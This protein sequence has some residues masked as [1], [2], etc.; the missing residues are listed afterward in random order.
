MSSGTSTKSASFNIYGLGV[1]LQSTSTTA[2]DGL[3]SDF[4][5]FRVVAEP[6]N[7]R[8]VELVQTFPPYDSVPSATATV[9]TPRNVSFRCGDHTYIDYS[10]RGLAIFDQMKGNVRI[11]STDSELL[12]E[13]AYLFLLSQVSEFLDARRMHRV[14]ALAVSLDGRAVLVLLPMGGGKST[15]GAELLKYPEMKFLS[16][17]SPFVDRRGRIHCFPLR[18]G[19]LPDDQSMV[20][21]DQI[22]RINRMEFGPKLLVNYAHFAERICPSSEPGVVFLGRR[23]MARKC[24][25]LPASWTDAVRAMVAN[26]VVGMGL[27]QGMEFVFHESMI[28]LAGKAG[29][30]Y[31]RFRNSLALLRR[32]RRYQLILGRDHQENGRAVIEFLRA[33]NRSDPLSDPTTTPKLR[34]PL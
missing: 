30:A 7:F 4:S 8:K 15:L 23:S 5:Y 12:Y 28:E 2:F 11:Y 17:D 31:S 9:Y 21:A 32:S 20:P 16:D 29:I 34:T 24:E 13:A 33:V 25:I 6:R 26:C 22:R 19:L 10:G 18:L 27:F 14:H 1:H 3:I